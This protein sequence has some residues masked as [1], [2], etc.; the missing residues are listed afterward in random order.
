M[1]N[2]V[3]PNILAKIKEILTKNNGDKRVFFKLSSGGVANLVETNFKV[4][5]G[6][7]LI[8]E[9]NKILK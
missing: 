9:I 7:T 5:Y 6:R 8:E 3:D 4:N 2:N 1:N